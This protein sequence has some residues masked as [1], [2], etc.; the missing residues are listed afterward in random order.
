MRLSEVTQWQLGL[1]KKLHRWSSLLFYLFI[2]KCV[3][4]GYTALSSLYNY[5]FGRLC[6][7]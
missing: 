3:F 4:S 2:I 1:T 6:E 7:S 5:L